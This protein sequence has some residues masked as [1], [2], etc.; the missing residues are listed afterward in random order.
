MSKARLELKPRLIVEGMR[1]LGPGKADLL[2]RIDSEGSISA[3][4]KSL[5]MSYARAW[6]LVA[7]MNAAF[8]KPLVLLSTGGKAG[9]GAQ[10][11]EE[12]R[13][14]LTLYR[15][16]QEAVEKAASVKARALL[17]RLK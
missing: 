14:V 11:T 4:A 5:D 10:L 2:E 8:K 6:K 16:L 12:G 17:K 1:A 3:A 7:E 13:A 9:G 15:A